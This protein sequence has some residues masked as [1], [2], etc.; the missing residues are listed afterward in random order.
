M[1][2]KFLSSDLV[3]HDNGF[4]VHIFP[5]DR[6]NMTKYPLFVLSYLVGSRFCHIFV[7]LP[8]YSNFKGLNLKICVFQD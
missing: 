7:A 6:K 8:E 2:A 4:K 5:E 3:T 1:I